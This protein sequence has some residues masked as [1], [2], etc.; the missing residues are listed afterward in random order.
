MPRIDCRLNAIVDAGLL[1]GA[2]LPALAKAAAEGGATLIQY[3]DKTGS[4]RA[5]VETAASI[6]EAFSR[7]TGLGGRKME[8]EPVS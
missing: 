1:A 4:T 5:M 6:R 8:L 2:D 7:L 3:R